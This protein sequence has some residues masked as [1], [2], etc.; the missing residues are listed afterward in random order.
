MKDK[1]KVEKVI[2]NLEPQLAPIIKMTSKDNENPIIHS[3]NTTSLNSSRI[4][5]K[6][7]NNLEWWRDDS[8]HTIQ[9]NSFRHLLLNH[10]DP[11]DEEEETSESDDDELELEKVGNK[12]DG[13]PHSIDAQEVFG[14]L[15]LSPS[16]HIFSLYF[17]EITFEFE[18]DVI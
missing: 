14:K 10:E 8:I 6:N 15:S 18:F 13:K 17:L 12:K 4:N 2:S 11:E 7:G 9:P 16:I 5:N 3:T 1:K